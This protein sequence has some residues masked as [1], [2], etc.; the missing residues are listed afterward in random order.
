MGVDLSRRFRPDPTVLRATS[1]ILF[2]GRLVEKKGLRHLIDAMPAI[3]AE[4]P[5]A[6]LAVAGFGPH[7]GLNVVLLRYLCPFASLL[8][9]GRP[10]RLAGQDSRRGT[11]VQRH[12]VLHDRENGQEWLPLANLGQEQARLSMYDSLLSRSVSMPPKAHRWVPEMLEI[13]KTFQDAGPKKRAGDG[14]ARAP[15]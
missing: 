5:H 13:A 1:E 6:T 10:V 15:L 3:L 7:M 12:A 9:D 14:T 11:F 8:L 2:V 4:V